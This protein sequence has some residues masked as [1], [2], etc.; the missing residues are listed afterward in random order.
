[1]RSTPNA[2]DRSPSVT[3]FEAAPANVEGSSAASV[4]KKTQLIL[5]AFDGTK[6]RLGLTALARSAG[7]SKTT[8]YRLAQEL[9]ELGFLDRQDS[10]YQL[11][12]RIFELGHLVPAPARLRQIARPIMVDLHAATKAALHLMVPSGLEILCIESLAG[13]NETAAQAMAGTRAPIWYTASGKLFLAYDAHCEKALSQLDESSTEPLTRHSA[14]TASQL[15]SQLA[16]I[17]A[18][19]WSQEHEERVEGRKSLAAPITLWDSERVVAAL[20]LTVGI[21]RRDDPNMVKFLM[22]AAAD[23]SRRLQTGSA[24]AHYASRW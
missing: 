11:G 3:D 6:P 4:L 2:N 16:T 18:R 20:S 7:L 14:R 13:R 9:C 10:E 5:S 17:R 1:M 24:P 19:R 8:T 15:R 23:I 22:S 12:W 21:T